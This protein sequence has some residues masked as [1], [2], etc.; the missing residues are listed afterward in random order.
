M[1]RPV[2]LLPW[3]LLLTTAGV[4]AADELTLIAQQDLAA[5][6][7]DPGAIDGEFSAKTA[8]AVSRF[9]AENDL[10]VTGEVTPQL[11][12]IIRAVGNNKYQPAS[13]AGQEAAGLAAVSPP[14]ATQAQADLQARQQ[15]CLQERAVTKQERHKKK[16][17]LGRLAR[18]A[19]RVS[20]RLA[21]DKLGR[22]T[23]GL[24]EVTAT[25]DDLSAAAKALG[26]TKEDVETCRNPPVGASR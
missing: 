7:Y 25:A 5:L 19:G 20:G 18:V 24:H 23:R 8:I 14:T 15:A 11:V 16:R 2:F 1:R 13:A 26:L 3:L 12:G 17:G 22:I 9:Q 10:E 6:G 21:L 4:A